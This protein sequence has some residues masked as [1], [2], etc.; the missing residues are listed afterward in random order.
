MLLVRVVNCHWWRT[1]QASQSLD[2]DV[3]SGYL[4]VTAAE[5]T[6]R[7]TTLHTLQDPGLITN[8][9]VLR[10]TY[11]E[12]QTY[13]GNIQNKRDITPRL[14]GATLLCALIIPGHPL[15]KGLLS[16]ENTERLTFRGMAPSG[17]PP[18]YPL[19]SR[20]LFIMV[21]LNALIT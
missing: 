3:G 10:R 19:G 15:D 13:S 9:A 7:M 14:P 18:K 21:T 4:I 1:R 6:N 5:S 20:L 17:G 16:P 11:E 2:S 12:F 8:G